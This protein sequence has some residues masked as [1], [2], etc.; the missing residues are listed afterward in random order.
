[1]LKYL[2][3]SK[4]LILR[5]EPVAE[6]SKPVMTAYVDASFAPPHEGY[7]SVQGVVLTHGRNVLMWHSMRQPF[8]TQST[9][10]AE[11]LGYGEAYQEGESLL[12]LLQIL[13][14][15]VQGSILYGDNRAALVLCCQDTGPW[16]TRRLRLRACKLREVLQSPDP[17]WRAEFMAG[18]ELVADGLTKSLQGQ[19]FAKFIQ[20]LGL[21]SG[22]KAQVRALAVDQEKSGPKWQKVVPWLAIAGA[23]M[24][25]SNMILGCLLMAVAGLLKLWGGQKSEQERQKP[26][27]TGGRASSAPTRRAQEG[28]EAS[29]QEGKEASPQEGKEASLQEGEEASPQEGK[30]ASTRSRLGTRA[31]G[32]RAFRVDGRQE[33]HGSNEQ[34]PIPPAAAGRWRNRSSARSSA[35][36]GASAD[37]GWRSL[38]S[39]SSA[40]GSAPQASVQVS[41]EG[42][43]VAIGVST[44]GGSGSATRAQVKAGPKAR[45]PSS[46]SLGTS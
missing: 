20:Q 8:I 22:E 4:D 21:R 1:M 29:P 31:P 19:S 7:R 15:E 10:E 17:S 37:G 45:V 46:S 27:R 16:R 9:A 40:D 35:G 5:F 3:R 43:N 34:L 11:L 13:E 2:N 28:K 26:K 12:A 24:V 32:I 18:S 23:S 36:A 30:G 38:A 6:G 42:T 25:K 39:T 14:L 41:I 44:N 33:C